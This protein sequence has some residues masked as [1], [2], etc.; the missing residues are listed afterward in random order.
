MHPIRRGDGADKE[1]MRCF[2]RDFW[3]SVDVTGWVCVVL[4]RMCNDR[5]ETDK[6][7]NQ[8]TKGTCSTGQQN[9]V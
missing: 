5:V 8:N 1:K 4:W 3:L 7:P 2:S 6:C 9:Q